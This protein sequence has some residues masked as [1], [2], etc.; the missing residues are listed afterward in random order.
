SSTEVAIYLAGVPLS[1][2]ADPTL[3][4]A[5]LPLWPGARARVYRS[6]APA[7]LGPGSLGGTL[8]LDPPSPRAPEATDVWTAVGSF[9]ARRVRVG[10][11]RALAGSA[12]SDAGTAR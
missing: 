7:A 6:F 2:G 10:D 11:I 4:L 8:V 9:G 5:T 1:G 12:G 3:D